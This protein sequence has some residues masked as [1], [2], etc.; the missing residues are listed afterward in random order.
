MNSARNSSCASLCGE[1]RP[2]AETVV[3]QQF[4]QLIL[5]TAP[6]RADGTEAEPMD[7]VTLLFGARFPAGAIAAE[8]DDDAAAFEDPRAPTGR[9]G[10]RAAHV[11]LRRGG[12]DLSTTDLFGPGFVLLARPQGESWAA[13]AG[14]PDQLAV[15][16]IGGGPPADTEDAFG[17]RY[18]VGDA[19]AVLVRPDGVIA[20]RARDFS[21]GT[22]PAAHVRP[23][24]TVSWPGR[25]ARPPTF[26]GHR[27]RK[28][29][30]MVRRA[31]RWP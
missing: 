22:D 28:P 29:A 7:P 3:E 4:A 8:A 14:G 2:L 10:S 30:E 16:R 5:R 24:S 26:H 18:R 27:C 21:P 19:G 23:G 15:H 13:A 17:R 12:Q 31:M 9:P 25:A 11:R 6:E 1:R 20:W